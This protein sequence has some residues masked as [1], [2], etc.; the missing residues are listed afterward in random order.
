M[1][2]DDGLPILK[3][4][5]CSRNWLRCRS[6]QLLKV[7]LR[8]LNRSSPCRVL[9]PGVWFAGA[10]LATATDVSEDDSPHSLWIAAETGCERSPDWNSERKLVSPAAELS[11]ADDAT[12]TGL[13]EA[14]FGKLER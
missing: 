9:A 6:R 3:R 14:A 8:S 4:A 7:P 10:E 5:R 11:A 13:A 2:R 12:T 1:R